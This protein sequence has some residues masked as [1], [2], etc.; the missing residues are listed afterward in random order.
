MREIPAGEQENSLSEGC[1][2]R[3]GIEGRVVVDVGGVGDQCDQREEE[4]SAHAVGEAF[5]VRGSLA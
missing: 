2:V 4:R 3:L 1:A 5:Q